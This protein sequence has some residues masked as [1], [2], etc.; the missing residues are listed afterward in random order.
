MPTQPYLLAQGAI[1]H[2]KAAIHMTLAVGP[3]EGLKNSDL[4]RLLRNL[5]GP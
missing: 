5:Y 3:S 1:A 4:G 2:L